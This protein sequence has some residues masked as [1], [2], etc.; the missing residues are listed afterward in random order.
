MRVALVASVLALLAP[1]A[2]AAPGGSVLRGSLAVGGLT[3]TYRVFVP[4]APMKKAPVVFVFHGGSGTGA[5]VAAQTGFDAVAENKGFIAVYPDGIGRTWNAGL[6]C[7]ASDR[8]DIDDVGFVTA[9]LDRVE[10]RYAIDRRRVYATGI[11]NGGL[12]SYVL[13]CRL[14]GRIAAV[15]PVAATLDTACAPSS[16]VSVLHVHGLDDQNIPFAGGVGPRGVTRVDWPPVRA[17]IDRWRALDRCPSAGR[18][19]IDGPV[20]TS[21]WLPC[22]RGTEVRL[23]T[24]AGVGHTWPTEPYDAVPQIWR[25]FA[26]HPKR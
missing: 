16:P 3:R 2:G 17:G 15:A 13:A 9:L 21:S 7:G 26:A 18:T 24:I 5:G 11:S 19:S 23:V 14:P 22:R 8:L 1:S 20:T 4:S 12:F 6:C 10:R 25:F